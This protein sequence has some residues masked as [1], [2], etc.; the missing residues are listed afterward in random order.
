[1]RKNSFTTIVIALTMVLISSCSAQNSVTTTRVINNWEVLGERIV[2]MGADHD[3]ITVTAR[4][5]TFRKLKFKVTQ[6]P[7]Y[8][9]NVRIVYG[10]GSSENH[11]VNETFRKGHFTRV[12]DLNGKNRVIRKILF[13]YTTINVG[14]GRAKIIAFGKR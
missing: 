12:L 3:E 1:M 10:N 9:K 13:N 7:I 4:K 5:G 8:V 6:A 14:K 11:K 2:N